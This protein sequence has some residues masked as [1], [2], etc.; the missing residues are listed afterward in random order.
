[1]SK[2]DKKISRRHASEKAVAQNLL[3]DFV[4]KNSRG[5]KLIESMMGEE[6]FDT[7][8]RNSLLSLTTVISKFIE[9]PFPRNY[10]R[11]KALIVKW[12]DDNADEI[13]KA[14]QYIFTEFTK[15]KNQKS[16]T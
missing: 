5:L 8:S 3:G 16:G 4:V 10:S 14:K 9:V 1:M 2:V 12:F 15:P 13:E 6:S 11:R 7:V